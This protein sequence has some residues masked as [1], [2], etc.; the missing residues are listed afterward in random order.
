[1]INLTEVL[2]MY[3][4]ILVHIDATARSASRVALAA[5]LANVY[6]AHLVGA[7]VT[8]LAS[9]L[10]PQVGLDPGM[11]AI[12]FPI[13]ELHAEADR[14]LDCFDRQAGEQGVRS[15]ERRRIDDEAGIAISLH[16]R[17]GDLVVISQCALDE[18]SPRLRADFPEYVILNCARP[19]L[20]LPSTGVSGEI[21]KRVTVAWNGSSNAVHA[22]T[23]AI[24]LL[25]RAQAVNLVVFDPAITP[26]QHGDV[27]GADMALY[28]A[29]HG[30]RVDASCAH[31]GGDAGEALLSF[32]AEH[33]ADLIVMGA[34]GHSRLSE[35]LLG[36]ASRTALLSSPIPLWMAH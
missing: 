8:G 6:D 22:I 13:D 7:A 17:Y 11:A 15:F 32:A 20:V 4:T 36:G 16:A 9:Y 34:Y 18:F 12:A 19:V 14:A 25:Q 23:S 27:P 1:M 26:D 5:Q 29:R 31:A 33:G 21:G 30:I 28:L 24:P 35:I 3:K 10:L 2:A